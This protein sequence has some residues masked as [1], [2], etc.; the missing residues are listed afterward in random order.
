MNENHGHQEKANQHVQKFYLD[1]LLTFRRKLML[2]FAGKAAAGS[3]VLTR[4]QLSDVLSYRKKLWCIPND[5]LYGVILPRLAELGLLRK[6]EDLG[7]QQKRGRPASVY[8]LKYFSE[9]ERTTP[10]LH[11][12][13]LEIKAEIP[14]LEQAQGNMEVRMGGQAR[15]TSPEAFHA[16]VA[17]R[18]ELRVLTVELTARRLKGE[19]S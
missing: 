12:R 5:L 17:L 8:E 1:R 3:V 11:N 15:R 7:R 13:I 18:S 2:V 14:L 9:L 10:E 19:P 6:V 4:E 16:L